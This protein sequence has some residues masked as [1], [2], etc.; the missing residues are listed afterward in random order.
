MLAIILL[1]LPLNAIIFGEESSGEEPAQVKETTTSTGEETK[2]VEVSIKWK[3]PYCGQVNNSDDTICIFCHS[4][5]PGDAQIIVEEASSPQTKIETEKDMKK[6]KWLC[7]QCGKYNNFGDTKCFYCE[8]PRPP[9][10]SS[11]YQL[12]Y[13]VYHHPI[14]HS[15]GKWMM[16]VGGIASG[17]SMALFLLGLNSGGE[18][19]FAIILL[20]PAAIAGGVFGVG[21]ALYLLSKHSLEMIPVNPADYE[22]LGYNSLDSYR[23]LTERPTLPKP[24]ISIFNF[25][26]TF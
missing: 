13:P 5:R 26:F 6:L 24:D 25:G 23:L 3:C 21:A 19:G 9:T 16:I 10:T 12:F 17:V 22:N 1:L 2:L 15:E 20:I 7:P 11:N 18:S 14:M 8:E 4:K